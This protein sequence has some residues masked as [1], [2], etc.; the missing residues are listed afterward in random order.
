MATLF[1]ILQFFDGNGDPLSGGKIYWYEAGTTNLKNTWRDQ[2]EV[3]T[4]TNPIIL[5]NDGTVP[6][7]SGGRTAIWIR[8][9]YKLVI[10]DSNDAT[11]STHDNINEY[12][13]LD[14]TGLTAT[15]ADLNSTTTTTLS[16]NTTYAVVIGDRNKTILADAT[17]AGFTINLPAAATVGNRFR[18]WIKKIDTTTNIVTIDGNASETIDGQTTFDLSD[19]NDFVGLQCDGSNWKL[20]SSQIRGTIIAKSTAY[21]VVLNDNTKLVLADASG[22]AFN[23]TLP[24]LSSVGAGF[25]ITVKKTDATSN[26]ITMVTPGAETIDGN[27]TFIIA[28][29]N[30]SYTFVTDRTN[31]Y[32]K[33]DH[34]STGTRVFP[35][36]YFSAGRIVN[37]TSDSSH[38]IDFLPGGVRSEDDSTN[39]ILTSTL[40]KKIDSPW[41][42]GNNQGGFPT[43]I[44]LSPAT[45]YH[46]FWIGKADG[47]TDAGYDNALDANHLLATAGGAWTKFKRVLSVKTSVSSD[48]LPLINYGDFVYWNYNT[49][50]I[51]ATPASYTPLTVDVPPGIV[52][53]VFISGI[54]NVPNASSIIVRVRSGFLG[55]DMQTLISHAAAGGD[56]QGGGDGSM[57]L[58]DLA[59]QIEYQVTKT[60]TATWIGYVYGWQELRYGN[61]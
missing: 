25:S 34:Q 22:G 4:H 8:G 7:G 41:V 12:D 14:W 5:N 56:Q 44:S 13:Q 23:I 37:N 11:I 42:Q 24:A 55:T 39:L 20:I 38:D 19:Y 54:A 57:I 30:N 46:L 33:S 47:T 32:V 26:G 18:I 10:K 27:A 17:S 3:Q 50:P 16:K 51:T 31:W 2:G 59:S 1:Q 21:P 60:G 52:T 49:S 53:R 28:T 45:W 48:I 36:G 61:I 9:S 43:G 58:S 29:Q 40:T 6:D 35:K 15:I